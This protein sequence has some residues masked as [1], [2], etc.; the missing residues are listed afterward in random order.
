VWKSIIMVDKLGVIGS[1]FLAT[2]QY[3]GAL[4]QI[5]HVGQSP[6]SDEPAFRILRFLE[7]K[8][9]LSGA[10]ALLEKNLPGNILLHLRDTS[11]LI[12]KDLDRQ[13]SGDYVVPK[14][15]QLKTD[16]LNYVR[17]LDEDFAAN[18]QA[19]K[20]GH[21]DD[22]KEKHKQYI[23]VFNNKGWVK[24]MRK[25]LDIHPDVD[26]IPGMHSEAEA[27]SQVKRM[28]AA[29]AVDTTD[30]PA[31][32]EQASQD[33]SA[34]AVDSASNDNNEVAGETGEADAYPDVARKKGQRFAA[35]S[36]LVDDTDE[37][38]VLLFIHGVYA[39]AKSARD[40]VESDLN[41]ALN[42]LPI[43]IVDMYEWIFPVRMQWE[44]STMSKRVVDLEET[45]SNLQLRNTQLDRF[46]ASQHN[47]K[48][49]HDV[50]KKK[51]MDESVQRQL[52]ERLQLSTAEFLKIMDT[53][54]QGA[55]AIINIVKI[56]D[57][58]ARLA[59]ARSLL[60]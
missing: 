16:Y 8:Q 42:P 12:C 52:C 34:P 15:N 4:I 40:Q 55:E 38:E 1:T 18:R 26:V 21:Q 53:P 48:I 46:E 20:E 7:N 37:M 23:R 5:A 10:R 41:D 25:K 54:G 30:A 51:E 49:K 27:A 45:W 57:E 6:T 17:F 60:A 2:C 43:D 29:N 36:M 3:Y 9:Q 28:A 22:A 59:A 31:T 32:D 47:R 35:V 11:T 56:E 14:I 39:D 44:N 24:F 19:R 13:C 33:T 50:S 58:P